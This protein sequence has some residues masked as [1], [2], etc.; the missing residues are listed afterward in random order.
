MFRVQNP[1][2]VLI[3]FLFSVFKL[4][5]VMNRVGDKMGVRLKADPTF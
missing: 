1:L 2:A 5:A 3:N 4:M